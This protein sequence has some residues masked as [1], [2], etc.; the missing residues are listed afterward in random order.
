MRKIHNKKIRMFIADRIFFIFKKSRNNYEKT[1]LAMVS[2]G[3]TG[4]I[5]LYTFQRIKN[6]DII[7]LLLIIILGLYIVLI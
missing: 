2:R 6:S 5:K 7:S 1:Y 4:K 3:Y